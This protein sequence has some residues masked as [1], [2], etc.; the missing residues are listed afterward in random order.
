[1]LAV[2]FKSILDY[3]VCQLIRIED[4]D[5]SNCL[6]GLWVCLGHLNVTDVVGLNKRRHS[7]GICSEKSFDGLGL[8]T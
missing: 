2:P 4:N 5:Y 1:M 6:A 8:M 3:I 7:C